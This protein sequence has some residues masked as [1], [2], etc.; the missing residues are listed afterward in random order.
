MFAIL[1]DSLATVK[2]A[3]FA[4][5]IFPPAASRPA[6]VSIVPAVFARTRSDA[7]TDDERR[8]WYFR[9]EIAAANAMLDEL[10]AEAEAAD[11]IGAGYAPF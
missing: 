9:D 6:E 3:A 7:P 8:A 1:F 10:A 5:D 4:A 2:P 11:L